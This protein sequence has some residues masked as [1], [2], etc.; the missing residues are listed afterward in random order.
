MNYYKILSII[1]LLTR[2]PSSTLF[3]L[4]SVKPKSKL[5]I[6]ILEE[7]IELLGNSLDPINFFQVSLIWPVS[8]NVSS[9]SKETNFLAV[10][11]PSKGNLFKSSSLYSLTTS[12]QTTSQSQNW[13]FSSK[14]AIDPPRDNPLWPTSPNQSA[15]ISP[16]TALTDW[17][18]SPTVIILNYYYCYKLSPGKSLKNINL[19]FY[20]ELWWH[21]HS[22]ILW[23]LR[24][25][26]SLFDV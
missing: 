3:N 11:S 4:A 5:S 19:K 6:L 21:L 17:S 26:L 24:T 13:K 1:S 20:K 16:E 18:N 8:S 10:F 9:V 15:K 25:A 2:Q 14:G 12:S 22:M 23:N 7:K